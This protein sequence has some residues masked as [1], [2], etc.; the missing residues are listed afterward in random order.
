MANDVVK[1]GMVVSLAYKLTADG[2]EIEEATADDPLDYL[3]GADNILP[4]LER[5]LTGKK[6]GDKLK[7]TLQPEDAYGE[8]DPEDY[9]EITRSDLPDDIE[10]GMEVLIE[11]DAGNVAE[12]TIK[13]VT[14]DSVVLDFNLPLAGK[15]VVYE[16][17]I[18]S[19]READKEEL[20]HGHPH[21]ED[22]E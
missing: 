2:E 8:Y 4:S 9:E 15:V 13:D 17:E 18:I 7:V 20:E 1:D 19:I 3:H 10:E 11:D 21:G 5:E 16:V 6:V 14:D 12:A 22:D